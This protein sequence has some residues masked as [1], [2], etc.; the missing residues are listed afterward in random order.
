MARWPYRPDCY[1]ATAMRWHS[2]GERA[3]AGWPPAPE[4]DPA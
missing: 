4:L 2:T 1:V 3:G